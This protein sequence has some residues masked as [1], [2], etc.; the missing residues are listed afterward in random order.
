MNIVTYFVPK[1]IQNEEKRN[2][3]NKRFF[4]EIAVSNTQ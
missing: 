2:K 1:T 4:M 3:K